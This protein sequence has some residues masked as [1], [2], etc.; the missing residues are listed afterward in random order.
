MQN[1]IWSNL[2]NIKFKNIYTAKVSKCSY[3]VGN[4]YSLFLAFASATS[5]T[6]WAI[7]KELPI[8]WASIVGFSQILHI[9]K[10]YIPFVKNDKEFI[11]QSLLFESLYLSYEKLW[12]DNLKENVDK[13]QIEEEFYIL[14]QKE[15]D[16]NTRFKHVVCPNIKRLIKSS[17][18]ETDKYLKTNY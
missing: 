4:M 15:H 17:D 9:A 7:W 8:L 5:V 3:Q 11:E 10:P 13:N 1:R 18:E 16:I 14:R 6:T 12:F 2:A